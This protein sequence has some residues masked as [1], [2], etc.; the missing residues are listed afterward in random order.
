MLD[1]T[2][3][4]GLLSGPSPVDAGSLFPALGI[5]SLFLV[6]IGVILWRRSSRLKRE[7]EKLRTTLD[8]VGAP[9]V[10]MDA[11]LAIVDANQSAS[12]ML[13]LRRRTVRRAGLLERLE[14]DGDATP[15]RIRDDVLRHEN[16]VFEASVPR[17]T[18]SPSYVR[19]RTRTMDVFGA[20]RVVA[21]LEDVTPERELSAHYERFLEHLIGNVPLEVAILSP[22][23]RY[24]YLSS[25]FLFDE[26]QRSW[27]IGRTDFDYCRESGLHTEIALRRRAHRMEA[28]DRG[29]SVY[30]EEEVVLGGEPRHLSWRYVP[31]TGEDDV[32]MVLGFGLDETELVRCRRQ[33]R[34]ARQESE[35]ASKLKTA[36]LQNV[37]H[38]IR[39]PLSS[40]IGTAQMLKTEI[41]PALRD[42]IE[43]VEE[44]GRRLSETLNGMLDLAG[45]QAESVD[46][47][48]TMLDVASEVEDVV[49]SCRAAAERR[50]LFL[51]YAGAE[52]EI[53][54]RADRDAFGRSVKSLVDNAV[55]FTSEGG[56]LIDVSQRDGFAYVR[57]MD[58]GVG[59]GRSRHEDVFEAF[60]QEEDGIDRSFEGTG[61]GL[62]VTERL[63]RHMG[64][65][66]RLHS[67]KGAG[68]SFVIRLPLIMST[69]RQRGGYRPRVLIA[70]PQHESHRLITHMMTDV[71]D[72]DSVY[73]ASEL[74]ELGDQPRYD[75]V[76]IDA[77]LDASRTPED[78]QAFL[79]TS[80]ATAEARLIFLG[81]D[82]RGGGRRR[83]L[84]DAGWEAYVE[85]PITKLT[86]LNA[87][88]VESQPPVA[89]S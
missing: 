67:R 16:S 51:E 42:F 62:A 5:V 70:D 12:A 2:R 56:I 19:V 53:L 4:F 45:L 7:V 10:V 11:D 25:S 64:G 41:D 43:N 27:L 13:G 84:L 29:E 33:L 22:D 32:M 34:E 52:A 68:S 63:V 18:G 87:L 59:I 38:E 1:A 73:S 66:V 80:P 89:V 37:S 65:D 81:C 44:N 78:L 31:F 9:V 23:G 76:L 40:I 21:L 28:I 48:P 77:R 71:F 54:V 49:R 24:R 8:A 39:T 79:R 60:R 83:E 47:H 20:V 30:F 14:T 75:L 74:A 57:V 85:K 82:P 55:K 61:V 88:Y 72:F 69:L 6:V 36:L 17:K 35:K 15:E 3:L 50:G 46:L 26:R 86:L 58:T